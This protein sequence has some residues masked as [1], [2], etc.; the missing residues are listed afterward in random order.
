MFLKTSP[1]EWLQH[2][3]TF[4]PFEKMLVNVCSFG[5]NVNVVLLADLNARVENKKVEGMV[6]THGVQ[7]RNKNGEQMT[8]L[9]VDNTPTVQ[10]GA[11]T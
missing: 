3:S 1:H 7:G 4:I 10:Y 2:K 6:G 11:A 8:G 9:Y 5:M